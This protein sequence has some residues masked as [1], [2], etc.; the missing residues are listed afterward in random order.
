MGH[1]PEA[2]FETFTLTGEPERLDKLLAARYPSLSRTHL[3]RL[4]EQGN[5]LV[6][7]SKV[8]SNYK[9]GAGDTIAVTIPPPDASTPQPEDIPV[10][11]VYEDGDVIVI[12]KPAGLTVHPAPGHT[13]HTLVNA[14]LARWPEMVP[15]S[16]THLTLPTN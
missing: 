9:A 4:I 13:Q 11:I 2:L 12:N 1:Q 14:L 7:G 15:V 10:E 5:V 8:R 6:N 16:Y 3:Q